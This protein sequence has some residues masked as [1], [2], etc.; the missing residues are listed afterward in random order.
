MN[1]LSRTLL[2]VA[3]ALPSLAGAQELALQRGAKLFID[4]TS[5]VR[6]FTCQAESVALRVRPGPNAPA[7][8]TPD[9]VK[10]AAGAAALTVPAMKLACGDKM[11][12]EHMHTA[13]KAK[14]FPL[15]RFEMERY[16]AL[17][18]RGD[19]V[20]LKLHGKLALA[21]KV[22]PVTVEAQGRVGAGGVLQVEGKHLLRMTDWGV[23]PPSLMFGAIKV[24]ESVTLRFELPLKLSAGGNS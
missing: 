22:L 23:V 13:L 12:D 9:A 15:V 24:G 18:P 21:G 7:A 8:L 4:G 5:T 3:L 14:E 1:R 11:M 20:P 17:A 2:S 10:D 6:A 16:E 19:V